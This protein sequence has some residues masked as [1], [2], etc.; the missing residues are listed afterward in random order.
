VVPHDEPVRLEIFDVQGRL[1]RVLENGRRTAGR[2]A[3]AWDGLDAERRPV[4]AGVYF[5]RLDAG[6]ARGTR[7]VLRLR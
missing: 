7:R 1:V 4:P 5:V 6:E 3:S 2:Y